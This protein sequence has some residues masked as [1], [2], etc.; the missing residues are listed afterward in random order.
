MAK[1]KA[2]KASVETTDSLLDDYINDEEVKTARGRVAACEHKARQAQQE[3]L[4]LALAHFL[5]QIPI[6]SESLAEEFANPICRRQVTTRLIKIGEVLSQE[7]VDLDAVHREGD[8][9]EGPA[10]DLLAKAMRGEKENIKQALSALSIA[11]PDATRSLW[12]RLREL[13]DEIAIFHPYPPRAVVEEAAWQAEICRAEVKPADTKKDTPKKNKIHRPTNS[14]QCRELEKHIERFKRDGGTQ[15]AAI[16][17]F[18]A[19]N[20]IRTS[21]GQTMDQLAESLRQNQ[22]RYRNWRAGQTNS[23]HVSDTPA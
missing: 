13:L 22:V 4:R 9:R 7:G 5:E 17:D 12:Q 18:I 2:I 10:L 1:C 16:V 19:E 8:P 15:N 6:A 3:K 20:G 14:S 21:D 11:R 23:R